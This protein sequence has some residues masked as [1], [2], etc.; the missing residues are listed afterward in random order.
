MYICCHLDLKLNGCAG[1]VPAADD[2]DDGGGVEVLL[3]GGPVGGR[4]AAEE[5]GR[6][7][8]PGE[9]FRLAPPPSVSGGSTMLVR[10][11]QLHSVQMVFFSLS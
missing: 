2:D 8:A 10:S 6:P 3:R 7:Q 4:E 1:H 11:N 9:L 5:A